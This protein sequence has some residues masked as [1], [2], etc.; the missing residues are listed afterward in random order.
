MDGGR[1]EKSDE[2]RLQDASP[3][4]GRRTDGYGEE[5]VSGGYLG[6]LYER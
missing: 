3:E 1:V 5:G 6:M 4:H 2:G